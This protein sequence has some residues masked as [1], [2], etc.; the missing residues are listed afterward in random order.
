MRVLGH[1]RADARAACQSPVKELLGR[2]DLVLLDAADGLRLCLVLLQGT[3]HPIVVDLSRGVDVGMHRAL[4]DD[5]PRMAVEWA[6]SYIPDMPSDS[7]SDGMV[8]VDEW[9]SCGE[10]RPMWTWDSEGVYCARCGFDPV[11]A[12]H[13][14]RHAYRGSGRLVDVEEN[15]VIDPDDAWDVMHD[16]MPDVIADARRMIEVDGRM[17]LV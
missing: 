10:G 4:W 13:L 15:A 14:A 1:E 11:S 17:V 8:T 7:V 3:D 6:M 5:A 16:V 9:E 12:S 2:Y